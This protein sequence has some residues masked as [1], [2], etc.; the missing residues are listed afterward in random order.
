M[1][2]TIPVYGSF[3]FYFAAADAAATATSFPQA[4]TAAALSLSYCFCAAAAATAFAADNW[5]SIKG[6]QTVQWIS[7]DRPVNSV[8]P[9]AYASGLCNIQKDMPRCARQAPRSS[10]L[11]FGPLPAKIKVPAASAAL[12]LFFLFSLD[13]RQIYFID[14]VAFNNKTILIAGF[15]PWMD[16]FFAPQHFSLAWRIIYFKW[17]FHHFRLHTLNICTYRRPRYI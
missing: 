15:R 16:I 14:R 11:D 1:E 7:P 13:T 2:V 9:E 4:M 5:Q 17:F 8:N 10:E 6:S 12:S 3:S